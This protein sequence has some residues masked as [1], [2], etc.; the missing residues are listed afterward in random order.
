MAEGSKARFFRE[1]T[2]PQKA[3]AQKPSTKAEV[4]K[5]EKAG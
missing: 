3:G 1:L 5:S 2:L 4:A